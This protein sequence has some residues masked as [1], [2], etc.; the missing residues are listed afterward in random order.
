MLLRD[1]SESCE[2]LLGDFVVWGLGWSFGRL[3][4]FG[5][6]TAE[7]GVGQNWVYAIV[8]GVYQW[9]PVRGVCAV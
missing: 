2:N 4:T 5:E 1:L 7:L 6:G 8:F 9:L 3:G